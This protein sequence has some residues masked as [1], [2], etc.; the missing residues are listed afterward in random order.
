VLPLA[1]LS[2]PYSPEFEPRQDPK[3]GQ[4]TLSEIARATGGIER[5]AWDDAFDA[6]RLGNRQVRDLVIPLTL[7]LLL[8]HLAEI[9]GRRLLLFAAANAWLRA[10]RLPRLPRLTRARSASPATKAEKAAADLPQPSAPPKPAGSPLT[11]AKA[12][13]RDRMGG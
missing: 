4:T 6:S 11:R 3:E 5:T 8:L 7:L 1:P 13:A 10:V 2:L 12:K 9:G